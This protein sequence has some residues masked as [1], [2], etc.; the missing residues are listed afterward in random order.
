MGIYI[1]TGGKREI[2]LDVSPHSTVGAAIEQL[3][4]DN[5]E[6]KS[7]IWDNEVDSPS[8][9]TLIML[10][11]VEIGNLKGLE[12]PLSPEQEIVLLS[13]VHGG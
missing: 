5:L 9:N 8:P 10:D 4:E 6:L 2:M 7:A 3:F 11:G 1:G 13:V 12:T